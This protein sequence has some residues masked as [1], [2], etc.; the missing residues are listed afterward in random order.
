MIHCGSRGFGHQDLHWGLGAPAAVFPKI[1]AGL[2]DVHNLAGNADALAVA[3][4]LGDWLY[5][6]SNGWSSS[7]K[8]RVLSQE[9]G[10]M[11]DALY[12]LYKLTKNVN[13][14]VVPVSVKDPSGYLVQGLLPSDS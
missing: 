8:S 12:E 9:Y 5:N 6:R 1:L 2:L 4:K 7:S 11:N 10:G 13:F 3:S 14:V